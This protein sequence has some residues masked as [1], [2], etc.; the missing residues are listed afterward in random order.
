M[1]VQGFVAS[2][3]SGHE[4]GNWYRGGAVDAVHARSTAQNQVWPMFRPTRRSR[5]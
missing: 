5:I 4:Q 3:G 1:N 2:A